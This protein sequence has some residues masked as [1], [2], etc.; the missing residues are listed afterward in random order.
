M[1]FK[2]LYNYKELLNTN[3]KK[4]IR[5]KYKGSILGV[6]WSFISPLLMIAVYALV[7]SFIFRPDVSSDV[8]Y[9]L[10]LASGV[11]PWIF[12]S[13]SVASGS[14]IIVFN[15]NLIKKVYFPRAILPIS[16]VLS[17]AVNFVISSI[18]I[19]VFLAITQTGYTWNILYF[20]LILLIQMFLTLGLVFIISAINVYVRDVEYIINFLILL[21]MYLTPILWPM[22]LLAEKGEM[23][24]KLAYL[25]PLAGIIESYHN[26]FYFQ[27]SPDFVVLGL[28]GLFSMFILFVGYKIFN[29]LERG[30][31][32]EM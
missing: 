2:E 16:V 10:Y 28:T 21:L 3:V 8:P 12:F 18:V 19:L 1:I 17:G 27:T 20:P 9:Y 23:Y 25:N 5:G 29:K 26:I 7:F 13:Q 32:E 14:Q 15:A 11:L 6:L 30:F 22:E 24:V 31:A 4:E